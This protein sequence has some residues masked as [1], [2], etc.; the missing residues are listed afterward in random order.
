MP[1]QTVDSQIIFTDLMSTIL[2]IPDG[3]ARV[4]HELEILGNAEVSRL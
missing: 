1:V 4:V 2:H 3:K